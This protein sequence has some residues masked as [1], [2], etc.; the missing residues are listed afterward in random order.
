M[1]GITLRFLGLVTYSKSYG[2]VH[3]SK[4][5]GAKK[6]LRCPVV[7][8]TSHIAPLVQ[9]LLDGASESGLWHCTDDCVHFDAALEDHHCRDRA[10][11]ILCCNVRALVRVQLDSLLSKRILNHE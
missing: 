5:R 10:N 11:A 9:V 1:Q 6:W 2:S 7:S 3:N 8:L 4:T